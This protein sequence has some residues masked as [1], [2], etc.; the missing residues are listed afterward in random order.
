MYIYIYIYNTNSNNTSDHTS[1]Q[2][3]SNNSNHNTNTKC[4]SLPLGSQSY[5]VDGYASDVPGLIRV[6]ALLECVYIYRER[7]VEIY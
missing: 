1:N 4:L 6:Y 7:D 3:R 5:A 2:T